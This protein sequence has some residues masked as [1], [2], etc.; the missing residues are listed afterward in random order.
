MSEYTIDELSILSGV[1]QADVMKLLK[2]QA[3]IGLIERPP[4]EFG[5]NTYMPMDELCDCEQ[6]EF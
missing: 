6:E 5:L 2:L 1:A 3:E 4:R